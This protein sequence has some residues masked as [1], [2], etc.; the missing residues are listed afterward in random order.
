MADHNREQSAQANEKV[1]RLT[2][3]EPSYNDRTFLHRMT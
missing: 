2:T 3:Q 1:G